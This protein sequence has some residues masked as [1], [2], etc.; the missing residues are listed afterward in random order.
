MMS[1]HDYIST[2]RTRDR[3]ARRRRFSGLI[4]GITIF[5]GAFFC[6]TQYVRAPLSTHSFELPKAAAA[7]KPPTYKASP[8]WSNEVITGAIGAADNGLIAEHSGNVKRP[9]ASVAKVI[10]ALAI[11]QKYP[12]KDAKDLGPTIRLT[13][14]DERYYQ[15]YLAKNGIVF[16]VKNGNTIHLRYALEAMLLMSANNMADTTAAWAFGS[17]DA[18]HNY[19]NN[20]LHHMSLKNTVVAGD[21]SGFDPRTQSTAKDLVKIGEAAL[22]VPELA[23]IAAQKDFT[24]PGLGVFPNYNKLVVQHHY[25]GLKPGN[26]DEAGGTMLFSTTHIYK[27]KKLTLV[28]AILGTKSGRTPYNSVLTLVDSIEATLKTH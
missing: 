28:G 4:F 21:A 2:R 25:T 3:Q 5:L 1:Q 13:A 15:A 24:V 27:G 16:P 26:T 17:L 9:T 18:Y 11:L 19:A 6:L 23:R 12:L 10:T 22:K 14:Q 8:S 7:E 20:M